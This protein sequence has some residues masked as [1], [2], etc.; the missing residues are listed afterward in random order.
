MSDSVAVQFALSPTDLGIATLD[1]ARISGLGPRGAAQGQSVT[2]PDLDLAIMNPPFTRSVGGNLLFGS[3]PARDRRRLQNELSRRL[4]S[5]KASAT[6]GLG[7]AFVAAASPKLRPGEGRLALVLPATV[8]TG[9]SWQ[10]TRDLI[11]RDFVLDMVVTS[12]DPHR[13]NFSD[14]TDLSE[15][16]LIATRRP[17]N[18]TAAE[19]RTTFVNLWRNP[20]GVLPAHRIAQAIAATTP[21]RLEDTGTALLDVDGHHV[22]EVV[23]L[24]ETK[25]VSKQWSGVQFARADLLRSALRLLDDGEACVPGKGDAT[26]V[27]LCRLSELGQIGPDVRDVRDGFEPTDAVTAYPM[28]QNHDTEKRK[29]LAVDPDKYL[30]PLVEPRPGRRLKS[31]EQLWQK[32]GQLLVAERLRLNTAR[33]AAMYTHRPVLSNVWWPI[34]AESRI[35]EKVLALWINSS[36]GLLTLLAT[37]NTT[38]GS[39]VKFKKADLQ[40]LPVLDVRALSRVQLQDLAHLFDQLAEAEFQSLSAMHHCPARRALDEALAQILDLPNLTTLRH[41]L[42]TEPAISNQRL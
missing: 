36:F 1:R 25:L 8:C 26:A 10:Q 11:Q 35:H 17:A 2:L 33:V 22:G 4:R 41:L 39:W 18:S 34:N 28:V 23:S 31:T 38:E 32:A 12:H 37:R 13:W 29:R 42:A 5:R 16:L 40:E 6:A 19:S 15:A 3:L 14:S 20:H 27:P 21:A 7:A 24:P 30:A 9:P